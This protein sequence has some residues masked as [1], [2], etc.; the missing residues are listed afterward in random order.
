LRAART[1]LKKG[2]RSEH[3]DDELDE[4][5]RRRGRKGEGGA[6]RGALLTW[7]VQS[8]TTK[9]MAGRAQRALQ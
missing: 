8:A 5:R 6:P 9:G 4:R 7:R 3:C 2:E 1:Y